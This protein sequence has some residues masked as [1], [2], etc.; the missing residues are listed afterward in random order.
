MKVLLLNDAIP[1]SIVTPSIKINQLDKILIEKIH[2]PFLESPI[3]VST[4]F[5]QHKA[6]YN[7]FLEHYYQMLSSMKKEERKDRRSLKRLVMGVAFDLYLESAKD[8]R[9]ITLDDNQASQ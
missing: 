6:S 7:G 1:A 3:E 5:E 8:L 4:K 2:H 9:P